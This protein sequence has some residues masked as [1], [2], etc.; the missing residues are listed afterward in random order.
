MCCRSLIKI[1]LVLVVGLSSQPGSGQVPD[2]GMHVRFSLAAP[3]TVTASGVVTDKE[4]GAPI[5]G[6][7]VRAHI[8]V[9]HLKD[10]D[11]FERCPQGETE[12]DEDGR[13]TLSIRTTLTTTGIWKGKDGM[14]L[15]ASAPGYE[16]TRKM[17]LVK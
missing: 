8:V 1:A 2:K 12:T 15:Y 14:C 17:L 11:S 16:T 4:T 9:W 10:P 7:K 5:A 3:V 13:Y 6:A